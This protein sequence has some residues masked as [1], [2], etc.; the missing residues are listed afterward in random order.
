MYCVQ[1]HCKTSRLHSSWMK[2]ARK[3]GVTVE[4]CQLW[5]NSSGSSPPTAT[6]CRKEGLG[7]H[8]TTQVHQAGLPNWHW[9][10]DIGNSKPLLPSGTSFKRHLLGPS[11]SCDVKPNYRNDL[12]QICRSRTSQP[13]DRVPPDP[14]PVL[15]ECGGTILKAH[16][17]VWETCDWI[18]LRCHHVGFVQLF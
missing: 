15:K 7:V 5:T 12:L 9:E 6:D 10:A 8:E 1:L 17:D 11:A 4:S 18:S 13:A 2:D 3:H 16:G 14:S